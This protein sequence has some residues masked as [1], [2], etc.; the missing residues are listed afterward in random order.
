MLVLVLV[1]VLVMNV[2]HMRMSVLNFLMSML[3]YM[4]QRWWGRIMMVRVV[5]I[6]MSVKMCMRYGMVLVHMRMV[7]NQLQCE[8]DEK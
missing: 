1:L 5:T 4:P 2:R 3:M 8:C 6:I 7:S